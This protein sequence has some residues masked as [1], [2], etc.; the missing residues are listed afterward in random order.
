MQGLRKVELYNQARLW[1][2]IRSRTRDPGSPSSPGLPEYPVLL[3]IFFYIRFFITNFAQRVRRRCTM[4]NGALVVVLIAVLG[5][6][7]SHKSHAQSLVRRSLS[8]HSHQSA[9]SLY[10]VVQ[11]ATRHP[12]AGSCCARMHM[13]LIY[14]CACT[15]ARISRSRKPDFIRLLERCL[16]ERTIMFTKTVE[17]HALFLRVTPSLV[18]HALRNSELSSSRHADILETCRYPFVNCRHVYAMYVRVALLVQLRCSYSLIH[19]QRCACA[20]AAPAGR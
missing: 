8:F 7:Y 1:G 10:V 18:V 3:I 4:A 2:P 11:L 12:P 19:S 17:F 16:L 9:S 5:A 13:I 15:C 20:A 6:A 14:A